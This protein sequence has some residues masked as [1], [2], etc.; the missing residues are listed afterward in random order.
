MWFVMVTYECQLSVTSP[1]W[2]HRTAP[3]Y[4]EEM[5]MEGDDRNLVPIFRV[6]IG[7]L[8]DRDPKL[9]EMVGHL[10]LNDSLVRSCKWP[11]DQPLGVCLHIHMAAPSLGSV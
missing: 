2:I 9:K 8:Y 7:G 4:N 6:A 5:W 11:W 3:C 1:L 10:C